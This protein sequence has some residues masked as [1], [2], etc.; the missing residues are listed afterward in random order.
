MRSRVHALKRF[1]VRWAAPALEPERVA[2]WRARGTVPGAVAVVGDSLVVDFPVELLT[3][4]GAP[5][6]LR[7]LPGQTVREIHRRAGETLDRRPA[8]IV[9]QAG[10]NDVLQRRATA[11]VVADYAALLAAARTTAPEARIVVLAVP[12]V[13]DPALTGSV[14]ALNAA[15]AELAGAGFLDTYAAL[16]DGDGRLAPGMGVEDGVHLTFAAYARIAELLRPH[17]L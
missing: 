11:A 9:L 10:S 7:G 13:G 17:L 16:A 1:A 2:A 12:P 5:L 6:M 15:L 4:I 3:P 8:V 14:R